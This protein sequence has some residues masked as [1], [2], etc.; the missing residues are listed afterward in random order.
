MPAFAFASTV[1]VR[2]TP[3]LLSACKLRTLQVIR[4]TPW[5]FS[6]ESVFFTTV[7]SMLYRLLT[8]C[9]NLL[10]NKKLNIWHANCYML[11]VV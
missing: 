9:R 8:M 6:C 2:R 11:L 5:P 3:A 4:D 1:D 10:N 7:Q